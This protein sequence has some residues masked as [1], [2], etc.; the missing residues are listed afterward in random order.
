MTLLPSIVATFKSNEN[1][2]FSAQLGLLTLISGT[3]IDVGFCSDNR[4]FEEEKKTPSVF[5]FTKAYLY[6]TCD[7]SA[8]S[9]FQALLNYL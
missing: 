9:I 3:E 1:D 5:T 8:N 7:N 4:I 2:R 6:Q